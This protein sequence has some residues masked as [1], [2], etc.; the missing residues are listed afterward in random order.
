MKFS[1]LVA[2]YNNG[3]YFQDCWKSIVEQT[4]TNWEVIIVDDGSTDDSLELIN[5]VIGND[6]RVIIEK[7]EKNKGCGSAKKRCV[8]LAQGDLCAFLDPDDYLDCL[9]LE[10]VYNVLSTHRDVVFCHATMQFVDINKSFIRNKSLV[11]NIPYTHPFF[12]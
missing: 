1:I 5:S 3:K 7:I 8:E 2:N 11:T 12:F 6:T 4:Y 10:T 9:A